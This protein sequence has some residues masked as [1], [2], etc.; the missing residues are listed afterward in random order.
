MLEEGRVVRETVEVASVIQNMMLAMEA[1]E[2]SYPAAN[3]LS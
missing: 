1:K 2:T 3:V